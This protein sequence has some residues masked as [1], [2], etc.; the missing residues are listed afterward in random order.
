MGLCQGIPLTTSIIKLSG[1][2]IKFEGERVVVL[3]KGR[4]IWEFSDIGCIARRLASVDQQALTVYLDKAKE[5]NRNL[6][7]QSFVLELDWLLYNFDS[8]MVK[9]YFA[10]AIEELFGISG[11]SFF[12]ESIEMDEPVYIHMELKELPSD[13]LSECLDAFRNNTKSRQIGRLVQLGLRLKSLNVLQHTQ[14]NN[15][16][17]WFANIEERKGGEIHKLIRKNRFGDPNELL[18]DFILRE[19]GILGVNKQQMLIACEPLFTGEQKS[20]FLTFKNLGSAFD[21]LYLKNAKTEGKKSIKA[22]HYFRNLFV[23]NQSISDQEAMELLDK[24]TALLQYQVTDNLIECMLITNSARKKFSTKIDRETLQDQITRLR[25]GISR[26]VRG[27]SD[28]GQTN[29]ILEDLFLVLLHPLYDDVKGYERLIIIPD[30]ILFLCPFDA[31]HLPGKFET[32][33]VDAFTVNIIPSFTTYALMNARCYQHLRNQRGRLTVLGNP[34]GTLLHAEK[35]AIEV[36]GLSGNEKPLKALGPDANLCALRYWGT[37]FS[38]C[39]ILHIAS[40]GIY[41]KDTPEDSYIQL[42]QTQ[43]DDGRLRV[44]EIPCLDMRLE[45]V[46]LGA[47]NTALRPLSPD[48]CSYSI[49]TAFIAAGA[50]SVISTLWDIHDEATSLIFREY[51]KN[52]LNGI[53]RIEALTNAKRAIKDKYRIFTHPAYWGG[54][55][56]SGIFEP[57]RY[58]VPFESDYKWKASEETGKIG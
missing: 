19:G 53:D 56:I 29:S 11:V 49:A 2:T 27:L 46:C 52:I 3:E 25:E 5:I 6:P 4:S 42:S 18:A 9:S 35:E 51:Y 8:N 31:L 15:S 36:F 38:C 39:N 41:L 45:L 55:I 47:C 22:I 16:S 50:Q 40:H 57:I 30:D 26:V 13:A 34:D 58:Q 32:S 33:I 14:I 12:C 37:T 20:R 24:K 44:N 10:E 48:K 1:R 43:N 54:I 28:R 21:F 7:K 17:N 23:D